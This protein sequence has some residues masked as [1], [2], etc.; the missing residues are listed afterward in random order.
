MTIAAKYPGKCS[1][2]AA[3][4]AV[5]ERIEWQ[6]AQPIRH[7]SCG[8]AAPSA[9][10]ARAA[11]PA[12]AS[13]WNPDRFNGYGQRRGGR[14]RACHSGGNCSSIGAGRSCGAHDCDGY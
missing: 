7:A 1:T 9:G 14:S 4:I 11:A 8:A 5:G 13:S 3:P 12:R 10:P 2:C 6:K